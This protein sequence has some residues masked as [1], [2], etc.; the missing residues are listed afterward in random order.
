MWTCRGPKNLLPGK[1]LQETPANTDAGG[2]TR[3]PDTRIIDSR[4]S[5][6]TIAPKHGR[7]GAPA[8]P[9]DTDM[10]TLVGRGAQARA[11]EVRSE[12]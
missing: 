2:G 11:R 7:F 4:E 6:L 12:A 1:Y 8:S 5:R 10:D 3:T 9:V